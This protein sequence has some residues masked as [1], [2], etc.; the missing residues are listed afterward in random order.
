[1]PVK[2]S[3]Q[4]R[5]SAAQAS[6]AQGLDRMA[7]WIIDKAVGSVAQCLLVVNVKLFPEK[8]GGGGSMEASFGAR[9]GDEL[10]R[11]RRV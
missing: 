11:V 7:R 5:K 6:R 9:L 2:V 8:R 4:Q 10:A 1:M 3:N